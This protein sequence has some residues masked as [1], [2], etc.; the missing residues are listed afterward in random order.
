MRF[1]VRGAELVLEVDGVPLLQAV[2]S[3]TVL[4]CGG[5]GFCIDAGTMLADGFS[6]HGVG[7]AS[8]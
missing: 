6:V 7:Q 4:T 2:D 3:N 1:C 8:E 5:A